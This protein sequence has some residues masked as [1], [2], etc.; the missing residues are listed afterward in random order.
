MGEAKT[1]CG[2]LAGRDHR[3]A[4]TIWSADVTDNRL[5]VEWVVAAPSGTQV[6]VT[7]K[8]DRAG[9]VSTTALLH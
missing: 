6:T 1:F 3:E 4:L 9:V 8:H 2:Q 7:A 5:K